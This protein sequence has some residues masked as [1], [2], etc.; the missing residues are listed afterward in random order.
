MTTEPRWIRVARRA[1]ESRSLGPVM[2]PVEA[3]FGRVDRRHFDRLTRRP[4]DLDELARHCPPSDEAPIL[5]LGTGWRCGSTALQRQLVSTGS[6]L[7]WGEPWNRCQPVRTLSDQ[8]GAVS[9]A[10]LAQLPDTRADQHELSAAWIANLFPDLADLLGAHQQYLLR[11]LGEPARAAGYERWGLKEVRLDGT[12]LRYLMTLFPG[13]R[14]VIVH[15]DPRDAWASYRA[16]GFRSYRRWPDQ[17]VETVRDFA[18]N[19][20]QLARSLTGAAD[21]LGALVV[22]YDELHT[23]AVTAAVESHLDIDIDRAA[24]TQ[25]VGGASSAPRPSR[26]ELRTIERTAGE[27]MADLGY[28]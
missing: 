24:R 2:R 27:L 15:R 12:D 25:R 11:L 20:T 23:E 10:W 6:V 26:L 9:S 13:A 8:L 16:M 5:L 17:P 1:R 21:D 19:W 3:M 14:A 28:R 18:R 7:V 22:R 4:V